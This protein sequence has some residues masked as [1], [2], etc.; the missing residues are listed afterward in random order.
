MRE[1]T[2]RPNGE[3]SALIAL[4]V[5]IKHSVIWEFVDTEFPH[6]HQELF[7]KFSERIKMEYSNVHQHAASAF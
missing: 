3:C 2:C 7:L 1:H 6:V 5:W 4:V